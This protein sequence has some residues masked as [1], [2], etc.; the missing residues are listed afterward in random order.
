MNPIARL[1]ARAAA[2]YQAAD[3]TALTNLSFDVAIGLTVMALIGT[4]LLTLQFGQNDSGI[5]ASSKGS[6]NPRLTSRH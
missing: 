3:K 1:R 2:R 6:S 5:D 4:C